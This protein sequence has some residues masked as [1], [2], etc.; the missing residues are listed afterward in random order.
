MATVLIMTLLKI[1]PLVNFTSFLPNLLNHNCKQSTNNLNVSRC[2]SKPNE[3]IMKI[4]N[5]SNTEES[6][7]LDKKK[8][9]IKI[10]LLLPD[11]SIMITD[12]ENA[13]KI[14]KR[15]HLTLVEVAKEKSGRRTYKL[16]NQIE[17]FEENLKENPKNTNKDALKS[18]SVKTL[19]LSSNITM[20]DTNIKIQHVVK[21]LNKNR[22]VRIIL[23]KGSPIED[24]IIKSIETNTKNY[25]TLQKVVKATNMI[26]TLTP[27]EKTSNDSFSDN[28]NQ[29][30][31]E[32][33][34]F[35][36]K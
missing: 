31:E 24:K 32:Q 22:K 30:K 11:D 28:V 29:M 25:A 33:P 27:R 7:T 14:S 26:F 12:L 9:E 5:S 34:N 15:R 20:H 21:L 3:V 13:R 36:S 8:E 6:E 2:F 19:Q 23:T 17:T 16:V 4:K 35:Q 1:R 10:K 18:I